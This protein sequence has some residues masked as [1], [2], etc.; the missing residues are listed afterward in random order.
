MFARGNSTTTDRKNTSPWPSAL[1]DARL[2]MICWKSETCRTRPVAVLEKIGTCAACGDPA[3][4]SIVALISCSAPLRDDA[5]RSPVRHL[6][7]V[8]F[9]RVGLE[10]VRA[11]LLVV[12]VAVAEA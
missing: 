12:V 10:A 9:V 6:V 2:K 11:Q 8:V 7:G 3:A 1:L 4:G 5:G